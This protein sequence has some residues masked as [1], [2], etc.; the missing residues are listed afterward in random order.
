VNIAEAPKPIDHAI[1][2]GSVVMSAQCSNNQYRHNLTSRLVNMVKALGTSCL[3]HKRNLWREP[4]WVTREKRCLPDV[5]EGAEQ[6]HHS[7]Q[8]NTE[9][10]MRR[11]TKTVIVNK[12]DLSTKV[13]KNT[14]YVHSNGLL[15]H[16]L[17]SNRYCNTQRFSHGTNLNDSM[18]DDIVLASMPHSI[19]RFLSNSGVCTL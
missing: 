12:M 18:Y 6:H 4:L 5:V 14:T 15:E 7:L 3:S 11:G 16:M 8:P 17:S 1:L 9:T 19:A 13:E 2:I 10:T